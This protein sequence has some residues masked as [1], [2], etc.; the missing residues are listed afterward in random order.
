MLFEVMFG[1]NTD[2]DMNDLAVLSEKEEADILNQL[3]VKDIQVIK[4]S[5]EDS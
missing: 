4:E 5:K 3:F 1:G 2:N